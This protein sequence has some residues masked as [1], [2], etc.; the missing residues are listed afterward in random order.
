[1]PTS[2]LTVVIPTR[3]RRETVLENLSRLE[4]R[5]VG[6]QVEIVVV[7][8]GSEDGTAEA[9]REAATRFPFE[10]RLVAGSG[11]GPA[12]ARNLGIEAAQGDVCL[13]LDDDVLPGTEMVG[14][15]VG[16]HLQHREKGD[17]LLGRVV[18]APGFDSELATWA[19]EQGGLFAYAELTPGKP[20]P[21]DRFWTAQVS[22]KTALLRDVGG[23]DEDL[24]FFEDVE[25]ARRLQ[26]AGMKLSYDPDAVGE[27]AQAIDLPMLMA[28][29]RDSGP[30]FRVLAEKVPGTAVPRAPGMRHRVKA[31]ALTT[32]YAARVRPR[33]VRHAAWRFLVDE[34][35]REAL[36]GSER[37]ELQIGATLRRAATQSDAK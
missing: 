9:V 7:D 24:R 8:D 6:E 19:H 1:M 5:E 25:L 18:P 28:R 29:A 10:V 35:Q 26:S 15:H 37:D 32:S 12:A 20:V 2:L 34:A 13:F 14:R 36:W 31:G 16:F 27:H 23:F 4:T 21:P 33:V 11:R 17:A 22:V 30:Y 3:D